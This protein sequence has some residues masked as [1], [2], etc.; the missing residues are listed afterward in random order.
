LLAARLKG[1]FRD[2]DDFHPPANINKMSRGE[3][4][5][6]KDRWTWLEAIA[7]DIR[8][9]TRPAP[10]V[11]ACSALKESHRDRLQLGNNPIVFLNGTREAIDQRLSTRH[12][13]FMPCGLLDSQL[14][15]LEK[16]ETA[17]EISIADTPIRIVDQIVEALDAYDTHERL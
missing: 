10:L 9:H 17:I 8:D 6:D 7:A 5:D 14:R 2:A 4:L 16:P 3:P 1:D 15:E 12:G 13:H 11:V